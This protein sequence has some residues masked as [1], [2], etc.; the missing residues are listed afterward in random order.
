ML[1]GV[2]SKELFFFFFAREGFTF[3]FRPHILG[4][5]EPSKRVK[6]MVLLVAIFREVKKYRRDQYTC[7]EMYKSSYF[8]KVFQYRKA[9]GEAVRTYIP[10]FSY[11]C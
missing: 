6:V 11:F 9:K 8:L 3:F 4:V 1:Y 5:I 7:D 10:I 2:T